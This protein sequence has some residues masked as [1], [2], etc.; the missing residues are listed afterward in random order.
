MADTA[1]LPGVPTPDD[2]HLPGLADLFSD[3]AADLDSLRELVVAHPER[4]PLHG[5][6]GDLLALIAWRCDLGSRLAGGPASQP[7]A[8]ERFVHPHTARRLGL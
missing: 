3:I 7:T 2:L 8:E 6:L 4:S 1:H 5:V